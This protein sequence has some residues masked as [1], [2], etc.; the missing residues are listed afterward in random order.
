MTWPS[1]RT[2]QTSDSEGKRRLYGLCRTGSLGLLAL[3]E[4]VD[5]DGIEGFGHVE[6]D[7]AC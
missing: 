2:L 6:E 3:E 4:A 5:P 7:G 1:G